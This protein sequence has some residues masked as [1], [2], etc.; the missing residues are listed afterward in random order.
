MSVFAIQH[1]HFVDLN[2]GIGILIYKNFNHEGIKSK[3]KIIGTAELKFNHF[4][5]C[6][7]TENILALC[8]SKCSHTNMEY[9]STNVKHS[10]FGSAA[11]YV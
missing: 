6:L 1:L 10:I 8:L 9:V 3:D 4:L 5:N 2:G 11:N 7:E